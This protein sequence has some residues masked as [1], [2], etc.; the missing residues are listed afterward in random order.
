MLHDVSLT[1]MQLFKTDKVSSFTLDGV[2]S[3][4]TQVIGKLTSSYGRSVT[5]VKCGQPSSPF[6][7]FCFPKQSSYHAIVSVLSKK[8]VM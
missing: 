5:T 7:E 8:E 1:F 2:Q 4:S 6:K 3:R